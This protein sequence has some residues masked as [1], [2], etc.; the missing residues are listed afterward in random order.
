M[1]NDANDKIEDPIATDETGAKAKAWKPVLSS[2]EQ[3]AC[4]RIRTLL[5]EHG[6]NRLDHGL[7]SRFAR[8]AEPTM[9]REIIRVALEVLAEKIDAEIELSAKVGG[10]S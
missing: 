6:L 8:T 3:V 7:R 4:D 5:I 2:G 10:E 9:P 1:S